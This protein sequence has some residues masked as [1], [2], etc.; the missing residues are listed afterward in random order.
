MELELRNYNLLWCLA[1][2]L[3]KEKIVLKG[4]VFEVFMLITSTVA[5]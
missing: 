3:V 5:N 4:T 1:I 2:F